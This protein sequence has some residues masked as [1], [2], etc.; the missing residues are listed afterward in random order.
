MPEDFETKLVAIAERTMRIKAHCV[1]EDAT[2]IYLVMPFIELLGYDAGDPAVIVPEF[3]ERIGFAIMVDGQPAIGLE[4]V[5]SARPSHQA[6]QRMRAFCDSARPAKLGIATNGVV[7]EAFIDSQ[8]PDTLD[9]DPFL[10]IDLARIAAGDIDRQSIDLLKMVRAA[11]Y[12]ASAIAEQAFA[13]SL[14]E[15]LKESV[16]EEFRNP[17]ELLCRLLLERIGIRNAKA[18]VIDQH[19]RSIVKAAMEQAVIVPVIQALRQLPAPAKPVAQ[20]SI[21]AVETLND[22]L[23]AF[24]RA[25]RRSA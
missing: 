1:G 18:G 9:T 16:L 22:E 8:Q 10:R 25:K 19:Y 23:A 4:A 20:K 21:K 7:F 3:E 5:S 14:R 2:R 17:S 11:N 12:N 24:G 15:R 13:I 6:Q